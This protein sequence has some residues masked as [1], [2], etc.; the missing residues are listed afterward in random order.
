MEM[1]WKEVALKSH[2]TYVETRDGTLPRTFRDGYNGGIW[3]VDEN[4]FRSTQDTNSFARLPAKIQQIE[5]LLQINW[6][7]VEW[8]DLRKPLYSA[9]AARLIIFNA[10]ASV[11]PTNDLMGQAQFWMQYYNRNGEASNF[12]TT[13]SGLQG[14]SVIS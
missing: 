1:K 9:L 4:A 7:D 11:P 12:V 8:R 14:K 6:L 13:S 5:E 10:P 2:H 3:A